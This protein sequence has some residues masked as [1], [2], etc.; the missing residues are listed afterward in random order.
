MNLP[1]AIGYILPNPN[2]EAIRATLFSSPPKHTH[3]PSSFCYSPQLLP[4]RRSPA[5]SHFPI[6]DKLLRLNLS[7]FH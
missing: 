6:I 4:S 3:T 5:T 7:V 2:M 1:S